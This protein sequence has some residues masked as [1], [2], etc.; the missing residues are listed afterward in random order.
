MQNSQKKYSIDFY[1]L[2][3]CLLVISLPFSKYLL[4]ISQF[5]IFIAWLVSGNLKHKLTQIVND[6]PVLLFTLIYLVHLLGLIYTSDFDYAFKDLRIKLPLL[7]LPVVISTSEKLDEKKLK[8][9]LYLFVLAILLSSLYSL[10]VLLKIDVFFDFFEFI[11]GRSIELFD[12]RDISV[13]I[14]HIRLALLINMGIFILFYYLYNEKSTKLRIV[15]S[16][17]IAWFI[18]FL[19]I[20]QSLTGLVILF[21]VALILFIRWIYTDR[22]SVV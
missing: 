15:I 5:L 9:L 2:F 20:L 17:L 1:Y 8:K 22:K 11:K 13:F 21:A 4:S 7:I 18:F 3:L 6:K 16:V 19:L 14:S 10:G 12:K